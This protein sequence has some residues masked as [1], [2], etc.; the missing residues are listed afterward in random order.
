MNTINKDDMENVIIQML[1]Q[2]VTREYAAEIASEII[3]E[4]IEDVETTA[5][6][7]YCDTD[8]RYAIGRTLAYRLGCE[9]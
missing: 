5:N 6:E 8:I 7:N 1:I 3:D 2:C 4:V 9:N